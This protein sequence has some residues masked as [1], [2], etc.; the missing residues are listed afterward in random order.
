[1]RYRPIDLEKDEIRLLE[2]LPTKDQDFFHFRLHHFPLNAAPKFWALSYTWGE[3]T[4]RPRIIVDGH[5]FEVTHNLLKAL[6]DYTEVVRL[7]RTYSRWKEFPHYRVRFIWVG[8]ICINQTDLEE[9]AQEVLRMRHIYETAMVYV[10]L[11]IEIEVGVTAVNA[12]YSMAENRFDELDPAASHASWLSLCKLFSQPWFT[13]V[14]VI[15]EFV[16]ARYLMFFVGVAPLPPL[17]LFRAALEIFTTIDDV[18]L[19]TDEKRLL[20]SG[21]KQF[22]LMCDAK[23]QVGNLN[24][25][26]VLSSLLWSFRDREA[27][28]PRDKIYS[29]LGIVEASTMRSKA[30]HEPSDGTTTTLDSKQIIINYHAPLEE[31]YTSLIRAIITSSQS[32]NIMCACQGSSSFQR[33]WVPDWSQPWSSVSLLVNNVYPF[34][35]EIKSEPSYRASGVRMASVIFS[36]D[37]FTIKAEGIL[38]CHI[39]YIVEAPPVEANLD[40]FDK[41]LDLYKSLNGGLRALLENQYRSFGNEGGGDEDPVAT[42]W[43]TAMLG[44]NFRTDKCGVRSWRHFLPGESEMWHEPAYS[45]KGETEVESDDDDD[46]EIPDEVWDARIAQLSKGRRGFISKRGLCGL[47][48]EDAGNG[49]CLCILFGCDVPVVLRKTG[50][51]YAFVGEC[52]IQGLMNGEAMKELEAGTRTSQDFEIR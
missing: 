17:T 36:D 10:H 32:L 43:M 7:G 15:Q 46:Y 25:P 31:V 13:R 45:L 16:A 8:A 49:D 52:Y 35:G 24:C 27:T 50:D 3:S 33:S 37:L 34:C 29:L 19:T 14:W 4:E 23:I 30:E 47:V 9:R 28:D 21:M 20:Y 26:H 11:D 2:L 42:E 39:L 22:V 1:M 12:S 38:W 40:F 5:N 41:V 18:P 51:S 48:P 44:G 6:R